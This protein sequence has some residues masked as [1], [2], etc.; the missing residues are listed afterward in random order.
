MAGKMHHGTHIHRKGYPRLSAGIYRDHYVHRLVAEAIKRRKLEAWEEVHH[1]DGD[2]S[3]PHWTNLI[4]IENKVHSEISNVQKL[5]QIGGMSQP[6][7]AA[8]AFLE[9]TG[10]SYEEYEE[11][12]EQREWD[13]ITSNPEMVQ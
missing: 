8:Q 3:N 2:R 7:A 11:W 12:E 9:V 10:K 6:Q 1:K 4:V 13:F 5:L